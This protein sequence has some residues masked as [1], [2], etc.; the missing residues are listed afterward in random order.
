[1]WAN[2]QLEN[3]VLKLHFYGDVNDY[4]FV[5]NAKGETVSCFQDSVEPYY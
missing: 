2:M 1:M 4:Y 3:G 5:N